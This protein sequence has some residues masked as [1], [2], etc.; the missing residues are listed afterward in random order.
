[1]T[2]HVEVTL[3]CRP[4]PWQARV[5]RDR[6]RFRCV[7]AGRR[8]GKTFLG[9]L[10]LVQGA[11]ERPGSVNWYIGPT[12]GAAK[13]IAWALLK[14]L[15]E[16][17]R[18]VGLIER[19]VESDL[20]VRWTNG[21]TIQLK[22]A[23]KPDSLRGV[24]ISR[25]VVD[26]YA[27]MKRAVWEEVLQPATSDLRAPVL[28]LGTPQ[29]FDH[30]HSIY[31][32]ELA[33]PGDWKSFHVKTSEAGTI[34]AGEIERARRD[35]DPR[36]FQQEY[37]ASF[38]TFSGQV[39]SDFTR[40]RHVPEDPILFVPG[41]EYALGMDFGWSAPSV[42]LFANID[43]LDNVSVFAE[44]VRR[45]TPI[46]TIALAIRDMAPGFL[47]TLI[48]CDPAGA[49][50]SEAMGLDAI[51]ELRGVFGRD[52]VRFKANYP[53]VIQD[54]VSIIRKWLRNDKLR[55]S[56]TCP[57]LI[58]ALEMYRYPEPKD[59]VQ[60]EQ[61]LKDG[62]S[63]HACDALRMLMAYRFPQRRSVVELI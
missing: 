38:V 50:K 29:G 4:L 20:L 56:R 23:D 35:M 62:I 33:N 46:S 51:S 1:M 57:H 17:F 21:A 49:A 30:F 8:S 40:A 32:M 43:G 27:V 60:S 13:D 41:A 37:E 7:A 5:K 36:V 58:Q 2:E 28:F 53:G 6:H 44:Y 14:Q 42:V 22:G 55:I 9:V 63:D 54:G 48:A 25:L 45:E 47:P 61:P 59:D 11:A 39:Y 10:E 26:E 3:P 34:P 19:A 16:P 52:V 31:K 15:V 12:Y 24:K 18:A